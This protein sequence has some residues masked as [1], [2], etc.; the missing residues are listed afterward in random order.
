MG[1]TWVKI[2]GEGRREVKEQR[3]LKPCVIGTPR[4][5]AQRSIACTGVLKSSVCSEQVRQR[6]WICHQGERKKK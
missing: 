5:P 2:T 3:E 4:K 1:G 6:D